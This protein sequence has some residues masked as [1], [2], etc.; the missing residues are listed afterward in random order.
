MNLKALIADQSHACGFF[1]LASTL[2]ISPPPYITECPS[3]LRATELI[4][5]S[6]PVFLTLRVITL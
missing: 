3:V 6:F 4:A 1:N 2:S 5:S